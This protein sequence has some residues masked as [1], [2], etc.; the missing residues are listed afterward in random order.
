MPTPHGWQLTSA[1]GLIDKNSFFVL[2]HLEP[3]RIF[4][5][6]GIGSAFRK[7]STRKMESNISAC[8][9][10][11]QYMKR[12]LIIT[13]GYPN[14]CRICRCAPVYR[15]ASRRSRIRYLSPVSMTP[16]ST[17]VRPITRRNSKGA[18]PWVAIRS[19]RHAHYAQCWGGHDARY[20]G[21]HGSGR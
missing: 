17:G 5:V 16:P 9:A 13:Q 1:C 15:F 12:S 20:V 4:S 2:P 3:S 8:S 6:F 14:S 10:Y 7:R 21:F 11:W 18:R 19:R